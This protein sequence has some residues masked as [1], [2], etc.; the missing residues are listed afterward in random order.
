M[1]VRFPL[2]PQI[3]VVV[4]RED[5]TLAVFK[6]GFDPRRLHEVIPSLTREAVSYTHTSYNGPKVPG[7][8]KG[9]QGWSGF[10]PVSRGWLGCGERQSFPHKGTCNV[11]AVP[12]IVCSPSHGFCSFQG[13]APVLKTGYT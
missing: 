3:G 9:Y 12:K 8:R 13:E 4:Q 10:S 6:C 1:R 11:P 2:A 7:P 5:G